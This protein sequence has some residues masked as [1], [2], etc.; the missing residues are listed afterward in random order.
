VSCLVLTC[1]LSC[2]DL[3]IV[4]SYLAL[5]YLALPCFVRLLSS[6]HVLSC[7][8][9]SC[10][11]LSCLV[12]ICLLV[13]VAFSY[14]FHVLWLSCLVVVFS[15]DCLFCDCLPFSFLLI[16]SLP[17]FAL[18]F[19]LI[20]AMPL[21]LSRGGWGGGIFFCLF[22]HLPYLIS[23][24]LSLLSFDSVGPYVLKCQHVDEA[25]MVNLPPPPPP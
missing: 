2:L 8:V 7:L 25:A 10:L 24:L 11:V 23:D 15:Y 4:L 19:S 14:R 12:L 22:V 6:C 20:F 16:K 18:V 9:L 17:F 21:P 1:V 3:C 5:P 13:V